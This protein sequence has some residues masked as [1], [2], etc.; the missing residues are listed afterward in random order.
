MIYKRE[1]TRSVSSNYL[2]CEMVNI[3]EEQT[4]QA[5]KPSLQ[6]ARSNRSASAQRSP[7]SPRS[8][9]VKKS[10]LPTKHW[11]DP[12]AE[13]IQ[14]VELEIEEQQSQNTHQTQNWTS[15]A[16]NKQTKKPKLGGNWRNQRRMR[17]EK[18]IQKFPQESKIKI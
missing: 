14:S 12:Q 4:H 2:T 3:H 18:K 1:K 13:M 7:A 17:S 8:V 9:S 5:Q 16:E 15:K 11:T 10:Q 6:A